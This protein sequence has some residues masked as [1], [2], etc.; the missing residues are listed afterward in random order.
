MSFAVILQK[1]Y[2]QHVLARNTIA[3]V[4]GSGPLQALT[5]IFIGSRFVNADPESIQDRHGACACCCH[6]RQPGG[7]PGTEPWRENDG[8]QLMILMHRMLDS[9]QLIIEICYSQVI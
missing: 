2:G 3:S 7:T 5:V 9:G 8:D 6:L 4:A 1:K